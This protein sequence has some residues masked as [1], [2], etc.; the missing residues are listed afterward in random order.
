MNGR[1]GGRVSPPLP[2]LRRLFQE[3]KTPAKMSG[4]FVGTGYT[5]LFGNNRW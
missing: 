2:G 3:Q 1:G 4:C 5:L